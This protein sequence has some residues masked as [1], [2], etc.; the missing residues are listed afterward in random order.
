MGSP[1]LSRT[2]GMW[3]WIVGEKQVFTYKEWIIIPFSIENITQLLSFEE[4]IKEYA[5]KKYWEKT[6][7]KVCTVFIDF[8]IFWHLP[9]FKNF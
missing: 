4:E 7:R 9:V 6:I 2:G 1:T 8:I 3:V 5:A